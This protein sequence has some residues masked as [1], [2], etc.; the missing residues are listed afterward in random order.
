MGT[1]PRP[2]TGGNLIA[3][4]RIGKSLHLACRTKGHWKGHWPVQQVY[5]LVTGE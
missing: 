4:E 1:P 3:L 5:R 2:A